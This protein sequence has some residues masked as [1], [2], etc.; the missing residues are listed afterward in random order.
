MADE[1]VAASEIL[2]HAANEQAQASIEIAQQR[3]ADAE[4]AAQAITDAALQ[5]ELG[6]QIDTLKQ[7]HRTWQDQA[8]SQLQAQAVELAEIRTLITA[9]T[10]V[11]VPVAG[12]DQSSSI[13]E[14]LPP[15]SEAAMPG[16][17]VLPESVGAGGPGNQPPEERAQGERKPKRRII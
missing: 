5:T 12:L 13:Q 15:Q 11:V 17:A 9:P 7:E 8:N 14:V 10:Q 16:V 1:I 3:A 6:R 2:A 4:A